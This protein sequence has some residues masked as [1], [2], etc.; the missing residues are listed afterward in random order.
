M[1]FETLHIGDR[2]LENNQ[3]EA[4]VENTEPNT[5]STIS[6]QTRKRAPRIPWTSRHRQIIVE[7][8]R[9]RFM[10]VDIAE[11]LKRSEGGRPSANA[12]VVHM[13]VHVTFGNIEHFLRVEG[14]TDEA[15]IQAIC[16]HYKL[17]QKRER[18]MTAR[19]AGLTEKRP[20]QVSPTEEPRR[21][22]H[23]PL[24]EREALK[25][26]VAGQLKQRATIEAIVLA[27]KEGE[28]P[29]SIAAVK[30]I[31]RIYGGVSGFLEKDGMNPAQAR[32]IEKHYQSA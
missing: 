16:S 23:D 3:S 18:P 4:G 15:E 2:A 21:L 19:V 25:T 17:S 6:A 11:K 5:I 14:L 9:A 29:T 13:T 26:L 12:G 24:A 27:A 7:G 31:I 20:K 22:K 28:I 8:L 10:Y 32:E 30:N 1:E